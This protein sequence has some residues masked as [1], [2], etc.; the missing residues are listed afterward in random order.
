[1]RR[2]H[3]VI[4]RCCALIVWLVP[5]HDRIISIIITRAVAGR[6]TRRRRSTGQTKECASIPNTQCVFMM[7]TMRLELYSADERAR[8]YTLKYTRIQIIHTQCAR[9]R[10]FANNLNKVIQS[11]RRRG[12]SL[13]TSAPPTSTPRR[14][15]SER[16]KSRAQ[17][18]RSLGDLYVFLCL[19]RRR[20]R[21]RHPSRNTL[22]QRRRCFE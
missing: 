11:S 19:R 20:R 1:M 9:S 7:P 4:I 3:C 12:W 10:V 17:S 2:V 8:E 22:L 16:A 21:R 15:S 13:S 6:S 14:H 18:L 5:A